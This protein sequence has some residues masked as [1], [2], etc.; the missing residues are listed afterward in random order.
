MNYM[1]LWVYVK[2]LKINF[3][4]IKSNWNINNCKIFKRN[5]KFVKFNK[6]N[7][8]WHKN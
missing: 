6:V 3:D 7:Q 1:A 8:N 5:C 4:K 2:L